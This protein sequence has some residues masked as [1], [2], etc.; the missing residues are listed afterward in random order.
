V[1]EQLKQEYI[2]KFTEAE[3]QLTDL[4]LNIIRWLSKEKADKNKLETKIRL[5][6]G[7]MK[8]GEITKKDFETIKSDAQKDIDK[9]DQ[10]V[11][12][13][14]IYAKEKPKKLF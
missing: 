12:I 13:L 9:I 7:R 14:E 3:T 5:A 2:G 1:F 10:R 8:A 4:R 6:Q 11:N